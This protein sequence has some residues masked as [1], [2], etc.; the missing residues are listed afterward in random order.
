MFSR[1]LFVLLYFLFWPLCCLFFDIR[2]LQTLLLA[3]LTNIKTLALHDCDIKTRIETY[4]VGMEAGVKSRSVT[5]A[6]IAERNI[7]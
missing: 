4:P 5:V 3:T 6:I 1:S 7:Q 2:I